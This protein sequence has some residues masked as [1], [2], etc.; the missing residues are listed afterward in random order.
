[1]QTVLLVLVGITM[2]AVLGTLFAGLLGFAR[3]GQ[4]PGRGNVLMRW[5]VLLQ[6][7]ALVLFA[8]LLFTAGR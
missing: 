6:G 3:Q 5:R 2:L 7:V 4:E 1:M 8:L